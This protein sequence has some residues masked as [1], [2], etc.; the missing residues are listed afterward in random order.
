MKSR[1]DTLK[2]K[3]SV[4]ENSF[5]LNTK[6]KIPCFLIENKI[7]L[8]DDDTKKDISELSEFSQS[9][10]YSGF[11]RTSAKTGENVDFIMDSIIAYII[12]KLEEYT[13]EGNTIEQRKSLFELKSE[14]ANENKDKET[15]NNNDCC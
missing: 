2:W 15:K 14:K 9:N 5:F 13:K 4:E 3:A 8:V 11:Y 1:N 10:N 7:D 12:N 6:N